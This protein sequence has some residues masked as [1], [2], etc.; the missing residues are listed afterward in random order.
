[1]NCISNFTHTWIDYTVHHTINHDGVCKTSSQL[2]TDGAYSDYMK[3][4][5]SFHHQFSN[6]LY[7]TQKCLLLTPNG[8]EFL[9]QM[10]W[11][12]FCLSWGTYT[13]IP[14][15]WK[16]VILR[17]AFWMWKVKPFHVSLTL[18][19]TWNKKGCWFTH[20]HTTKQQHRPAD[21]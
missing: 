7:A 8:L 18:W 20:Q 17:N 9:V 10:F 6:D 5:I 1:M 16:M 11:S 19:L 21:H 4:R 12:P 15:Y 3:V 2:G 13:K 14:E